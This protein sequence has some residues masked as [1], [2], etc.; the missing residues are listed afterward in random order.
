MNVRTE[1]SCMSPFVLFPFAMAAGM[2]IGA[3]FF[4]PAGLSVGGLAVFVVHWV[5]W[6]WSDDT[7]STPIIVIEFA[8]AP[9]SEDL[10]HFAS[11]LPR[12]RPLRRWQEVLE[13]QVRPIAEA[14]P[15]GPSAR[16]WSIDRS[17]RLY[18]EAAEP[19]DVNSILR[20][21]WRRNLDVTTLA[22]ITYAPRASKQSS[23]T[24][25]H[26]H[27]LHE[28]LRRNPAV[29]R[30]W[31]GSDRMYVASPGF[32]EAYSGEAVLAGASASRAV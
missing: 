8:R 5:A 9:S 22:A 25:M 7:P 18:H 31:H 14:F 13:A 24:E 29:L 3:L 12:S 11:L 17:G 10:E 1:N 26:T 21:K 4:G 6:E 19:R 30:C 28:A 2:G 15:D 27:D 20:T 16:G 23:R 32:N